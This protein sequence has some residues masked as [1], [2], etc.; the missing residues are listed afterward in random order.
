MVYRIFLLS[1][2]VLIPVEVLVGQ[3]VEEVE[4]LTA[5]GDWRHLRFSTLFGTTG[6]DAATVANDQYEYL[7][8]RCYDRGHWGITLKLEAFYGFSQTDQFVWRRVR[9]SFDGG[10]TTESRWIESDASPYGGLKLTL[11]ELVSGSNIARTA[12]E[13]AE[14]YRSFIRR[15]MDADTVRF[16]VYGDG[17]TNDALFGLNGFQAAYETACG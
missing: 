11:R 13:R 5:H 12:S 4:A 17:Q 3:D 7:S 6:A 8:I 15:A 2:V 14:E 1:V 9:Y 16:I 10:T